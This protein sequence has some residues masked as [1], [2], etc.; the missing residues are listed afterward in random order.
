MPRFVP[1]IHGAP[2]D[3]PDD[4]DLHDDA[5]AV[6]GALRRNGYATDIVEVD[7]DLGV[8]ERLAARQPHAVFNLVESSRGD[9]RLAHLAGV[10]MDHLGLRYTGASAT[11]YFLTVPKMLSKR[12][13]RQAGI[14]TA[15][16]WPDGIGAPAGTQ[17]IVKSEH[18]HASFGM[19]I[20]SLV[21]GRDAAREVAARRARYGG[22]FFA[23]AFL[24]GRE[25]N[26]SL[27]QDGAGARVLPIP[28]LDFTGMPADRARIVDYEAKWRPGS[29][30]YVNTN[31]RFGVERDDPALAARLRD[32]ALACWT[33]FDL[34][35]YARVDVRLDRSG[36]PMVL[37][38]NVNP[39]LSPDAGFPA[40][41]AEAGLDYNRLIAAIVSA[42]VASRP[43]ARPC[44]VSAS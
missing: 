20:S 30:G 16:W 1:V 12:L 15:A 31:R 7:L 27:L 28:E 18:E 6:A 5:A 24:P 8:L 26:I 40:T 44:F 14:P 3:R 35:G 38:V 32:L 10:A 11:A 2:S 19:D 29:V 21:D 25:F 17:V 41:A 43:E 34:S 36:T 42:A 4:A 37:E 23:E 33:C 39:C 13:M 22:C 9:T